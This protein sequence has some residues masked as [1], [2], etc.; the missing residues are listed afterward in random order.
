M[1]SEGCPGGCVPCYL[2]GLQ[3]M[4]VPQDRASSGW[5]SS[6]SDLEGVHSTSWSLS[7]LFHKCG[8]KFSESWEDHECGTA[9]QPGTVGKS[10]CP[11]PPRR[12]SPE[13]L[14]QCF[15]GH[16]RAETG[17]PAAQPASEASSEELKEALSYPCWPVSEAPRV[18][19]GRSIPQT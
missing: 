1:L 16:M 3:L 4:E 9:P 6:L 5:A 11:S 18:Q 8:W 2:L 15:D 19:V 17:P 13:G 7:F 10:V 12:S 14:P